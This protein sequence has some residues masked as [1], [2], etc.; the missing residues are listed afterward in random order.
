MAQAQPRPARSSTVDVHVLSNEISE[1]QPTPKYTMAT[2]ETHPDLFDIGTNMLTPS[3]LSAQEHIDSIERELFALRQRQIGPA[4]RTRAQKG[5]DAAV[6]EVNRDDKQVE[7]R[8][9]DPPHSTKTVLRP[10][11]VIPR[12]VPLP[13]P[14]PQPIEKPQAVV[15]AAN[16][17]ESE[18]PFSNA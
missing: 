3:S 18:H 17:E 15:P 16:S 4:S 10:E 9:S 1:P 12:T 2:H 6:T 14:A 11:V 7:N 8:H 5:K 13:P